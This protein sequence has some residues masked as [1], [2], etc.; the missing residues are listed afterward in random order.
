MLNPEEGKI[1]Y[2]LIEEGKFK[3]TNV[4]ITS[5]FWTV[6]TVK[7][8][9]YGEAQAIIRTEDGEE[10]AS[11][12]GYGIGHVMEQ[13]RTD[14]RATNFYKASSNGKISFLNNTIGVVEAEAH[15]NQHSGKVWEWK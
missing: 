7:D 1:E 4:T 6:H 12:K 13:G 10:T 15:E 8:R 2:T 3:D 11:Y 14:F 5:I 9:I